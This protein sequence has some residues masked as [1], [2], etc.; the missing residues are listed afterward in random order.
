MIG[1]ISYSRVDSWLV[2]PLV[3]DLGKLGHEVWM[4]NELYGGQD[5]WDDILWQIAVCDFFVLA[6]SPRSLTSPHCHQELTY[7]HSLRRPLFAVAVAPVNPLRS[8]IR[9]IDI[10]PYVE[11]APGHKE[12]LLRVV[13]AV[14]RLPSAPELPD[15]M[16]LPPP[17]PELPFYF[18]EQRINSEYLSRGEQELLLKDL[19]KLPVRA[20]SHELVAHLI[21]L[22]TAFRSREFIFI[23]VRDQIDAEIDRLHAKTARASVTVTQVPPPPLPWSSPQTPIPAITTKA[24]FSTFRSRKFVFRDIRD[25]IDAEIDRLRAKTAT[26]VPPPPLP[27]SSPKSPIPANTTNSPL[28]T[29]VMVWAMVAGLYYGIVPFIVGI[30]NV[31]RPARRGQSIFLIVIGVAIAA[32]FIGIPSAV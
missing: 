6:L 1:F 11:Y 13:E 10:L 24:P 28:S 31:R 18:Q 23:D 17:M 9:A 22:L 19:Q 32:M 7:A 30:A 20:F 25:R 21:K 2:A 27:S 5:W 29:T 12:A 4:D 15:P 3:H 14:A 26:Q 16:P 8:R